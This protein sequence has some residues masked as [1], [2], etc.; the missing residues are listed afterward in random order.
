MYYI[1][2]IA[3]SFLFF[4]LSIYGLI[5]RWHMG[6]LITIFS[7]FIIL[8]MAADVA[9]NPYL[10]VETDY[11]EGEWRTLTS[12]APFYPYTPLLYALLGG[13]LLLMGVYNMRK[14]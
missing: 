1:H 7:A 9:G 5:C 11:I 13:L 10:T 4:I 3:F 12:I 2:F 8:A 6:Y 14:V